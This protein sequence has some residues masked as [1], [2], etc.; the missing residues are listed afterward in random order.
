[1][2]ETPS[3]KLAVLLHADVVGSTSLV[4]KNE[5]IAH[6]RI[7][8]A[9]ARLSKT[10]EGYGGATHEIRGD[11]LVAEFPR[12]SDAVCAALAFQAENI[13]QNRNLA[14]AIQPELRIGISLGEVVVADGTITGA[15]VILAQ[16]LE[17]LAQ[18]HGVIVQGSVSE[19]VPTR[20]PIEFESLGEQNLKG[21][22][23]PVR[24]FSVRQTRGEKIPGPESAIAATEHGNAKVTDEHM[25]DK[26]SIAVLPFDNM[27]GDEEQEYFSDGIV[28]D[29]ITDLSM[30]EGL[31]VIARNSSFAY[32]G[33]SVDVRDVCRELGVRYAL[34]GGVRKAANRVRITAQL[35]DGMTGG[36][37]WAQRYDRDLDD[38]FAVQDEVT[39]SIVSAL[40][41]RLAVAGEQPEP[42]RATQNLE[43][44]EHFLRGRELC[45][46]DTA[47]ANAQAR[48]L[49]EKAIEL[50][51][52]FSL[53]CS[54]LSRTHV[55]A[56][57]NRWSDSRERSLELA[58]ALGQ[59]AIELDA[60]NP[61][62]YFA[63]GAAHFW[64]KQLDK[65]LAA[66]RRC[67]A[68]DPN[69]AEGHGVVALAHTFMGKPR[70]ALEALEIVMRLDPHYRDIYLHF[71]ALAY[72]HLEEYEKAADT[73]RRRLVRKPD[74][75]ISRALLASTYGHLGR[76]DESREEWARLLEVNPDYSLEDRRKRLP[77]TNPSDFE[78][79]LEGLHKSGVVD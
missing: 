51:P 76:L 62:A 21:F 54:H 15:G 3:R 22:D 69:F 70:E 67:I 58:V 23:Q 55:I 39:E 24:A 49:L 50:D 11:A 42:R 44:Y 31:F 19:T 63:V 20:L 41:P 18:A 59:R 26:P 79:I 74:S 75:D 25:S 38:I 45:Y 13:E 5:S 12:A 78:Q 6:E 33:K 66:G 37:I 65:T 36:H 4:Q 9:F 71:Q 14:D 61:H 73:L 40:A 47:D 35:I 1:M 57:A 60:T 17:Q 7:Q 52:G 77:Y 27:S 30:I 32:K 29:I 53:A 2:A 28:E 10:I 64:T 48:E 56:Y 8:V 16:R 72:F 34:E 68:I 43:A 46:R